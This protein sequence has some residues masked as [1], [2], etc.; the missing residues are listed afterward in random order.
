MTEKLVDKIRTAE[1]TRQ[2]SAELIVVVMTFGKVMVT[3]S[4][5]ATTEEEGRAES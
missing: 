5:C 3:F 2:S 4:S 1:P